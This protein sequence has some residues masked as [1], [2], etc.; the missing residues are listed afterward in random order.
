MHVH[1]CIY[2][3]RSIHVITCKHMYTDTYRHYRASSMALSLLL[4]L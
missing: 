4:P 3:Y 1:I 2:E